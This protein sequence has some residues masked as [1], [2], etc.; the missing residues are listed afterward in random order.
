MKKQISIHETEKS[1][2]EELRCRPKL[3]K[4]EIWGDHPIVM[5][6]EESAIEEDLPLDEETL[7][8]YMKIYD[9]ML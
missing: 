4:N 6:L 7:K 3:K 2:L 8:L 5:Q 9:N 1:E